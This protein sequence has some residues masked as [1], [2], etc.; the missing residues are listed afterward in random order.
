[1]QLSF[2]G[3]SSETPVQNANAFDLKRICIHESLECKRTGTVVKHG[4]Q[5][6]GFWVFGWLLK[7]SGIQR[8][9]PL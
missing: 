8:L 3:P 7:N 2:F 4:P 1:M 9:T 6:Q 5:N